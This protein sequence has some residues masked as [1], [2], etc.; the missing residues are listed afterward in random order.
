MSEGF[1]DRLKAALSEAYA[2]P[3]LISFAMNNAGLIQRLGY[4]SV[5]LI[6]DLLMHDDVPAANILLDLAMTPD[7]IIARENLNA[8]E[9]A[10]DTKHRE[11]LIAQWKAMGMQLL[12]ILVKVGFSVA[13]G[14]L[15]I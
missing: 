6:I 8:E 9:L 2:G 3:E 5:T 15:A 11:A 10:A 1:D 7:E 4:D 14:G 12:P 13:S